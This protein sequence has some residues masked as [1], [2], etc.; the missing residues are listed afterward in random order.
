MVAIVN[1]QSAIEAAAVAY[2]RGLPARPGLPAGR[3]LD[4][5]GAATFQKTF[6]ILKVADRPSACPDDNPQTRQMEKF[7][8]DHFYR[9]I[10]TGIALLGTARHDDRLRAQ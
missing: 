5:R 1:I 2:E 8:L 7:K 4:S 3:W 6:Q 9:G 10:D